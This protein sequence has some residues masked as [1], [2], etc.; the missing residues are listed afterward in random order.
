MWPLFASRM[1][2]PWLMGACVAH[3]HNMFVMLYSWHINCPFNISLKS[4]FIIAVLTFDIW[5]KLQKRIIRVIYC[6]I[7][8]FAQWSNIS[9]NPQHN[10]VPLDNV[11]TDVTDDSLS[12]HPPSCSCRWQEHMMSLFWQAVVLI[13][14]ALHGRWYIQRHFTSYN[15]CVTPIWW[16]L[17]ILNQLSKYASWFMCCP[18]AKNGNVDH[19]NILHENFKWVKSHC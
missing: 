15:S 10:Y 16:N 7:T 8:W 13:N 5:C 17:I 9:S 3:F 6:Y 19:C 2:N 12:P 11:I 18:V 1:K 14:I 4:Y